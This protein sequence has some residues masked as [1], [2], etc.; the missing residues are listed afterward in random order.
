MTSLRIATTDSFG[1]YVMKAVAP[2][3]ERH[4]GLTID[5]LVANTT[6]DLKAREAELAVRMFR[7]EDEG[8]ASLKLGSLGWSLYAT[9][10]YLAGRTPG[11]GLL[12]GHRVIG[13]VES[14]RRGMAGAQWVAANAAPDSVRM[15]C[16]GPG[17]ALK[18]A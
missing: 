17:A 5:L 18:V 9:P 2:L 4:T 11:P 14:L 6:V 15:E 16:S 12:D 8:L 10:A 3:R 7:N 13:Y 1:T